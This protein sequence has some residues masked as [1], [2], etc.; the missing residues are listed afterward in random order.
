MCETPNEGKGAK[1]G[2]GR[3][4]KKEWGGP[5]DLN[6]CPGEIQESMAAYVKQTTG[7]A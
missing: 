1:C 2:T 3:E 5:S 6:A 4:R 7:A